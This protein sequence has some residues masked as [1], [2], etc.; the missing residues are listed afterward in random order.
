MEYTPYLVHYGIK[1][2]KWGVRRT[3]AQLARARGKSGTSDSRSSDADK[4]KRRAAIK[5]A[6]AATAAVVTVAA[7]ATLYASNPKIRSAVNSV[8][9]KAGK[10]TVD[11]IKTAGKKSVE[12]GKAY[13]KK[14]LREAYSGVKAGIKEGVHEGAKKIAK[15]VVT[16]VMLNTAKRV[17][18]STLGKEE[19]T[20][21][22]QANNNKK[23]SSF[24]KVSSDDKD[25]E[26]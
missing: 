13:A 16:G 9:S 10:K 25:D 12:A 8:V 1:G 11:S 17:L 2:M 26:D 3:D 6:A 22:F 19:T 14:T 4:E 7:A 18:D 24:W 20:R 21:I 15:T 23:I 5:K